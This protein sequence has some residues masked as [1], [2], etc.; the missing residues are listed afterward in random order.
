MIDEVGMKV[1]F[2]YKGWI[3]EKSR[4]WKMN[5]ITIIYG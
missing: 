3:I 4:K 1:L 2:L 5:W